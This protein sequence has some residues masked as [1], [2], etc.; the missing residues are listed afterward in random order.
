MARLGAREPPFWPKNPPEKVYVD[1]SLFCVLSQEMRHMH[2]FWGPKIGVFFGRGQKVYV[3][4]AYVFSVPYQGGNNPLTQT[5]F[6]D[7]FLSYCYLNP[8]VWSVFWA[9]I[10]WLL[11]LRRKIGAVFEASSY[12]GFQKIPLREWERTCFIG[13]GAPAFSSSLSFFVRDNTSLP[14]TACTSSFSLFSSKP[15]GFWQGTKT[16]CA[17]NTVAPGIW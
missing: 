3:E 16:P 12:S 7:W 1:G 6:L 15:L 2:F 17:K 14:C 4:K 11:M 5:V 13:I 9:K 10:A 8:I